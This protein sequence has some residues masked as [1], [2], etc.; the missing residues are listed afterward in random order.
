MLGSGKIL[1]T[2]TSE[3]LPDGSNWCGCWDICASVDAISCG[4]DIL[5]LQVYLS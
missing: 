1:T 4:L 2:L 3:V 5:V